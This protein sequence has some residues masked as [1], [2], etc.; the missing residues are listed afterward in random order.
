MGGATFCIK[1]GKNTGILSG[2][3]KVDL[4]FEE[5]FDNEGK[6]ISPNVIKV[7][8]AGELQNRSTGAIKADED[9]IL[10]VSH[11]CNEGEIKSKSCTFSINDQFENRKEI[12]ASHSFI[13]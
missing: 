1:G 9:L 7:H 6:I 4:A 2:K 12:H 13:S 11:G 3:S 10:T 8:G 5:Q